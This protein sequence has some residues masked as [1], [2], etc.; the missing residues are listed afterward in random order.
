MYCSNCGQ[1]PLDFDLFA[2]APP[3]APKRPAAFVRPKVCFAS[4]LLFDP[5][6]LF[7]GEAHLFIPFSLIFGDVL[8]PREGALI[9]V[10][11][12][13]RSI[14]KPLFPLMGAIVGEAADQAQKTSSTLSFKSVRKR[15]TKR[16]S[17]FPPW[18]SSMK[19]TFPRRLGAICRDESVF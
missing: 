1:S 7:Q 9:G 19:V 17:G 11:F 16:K 18:A 5:V 15:L 13:L 2:L 14:V 6:A 12:N 8:L 3:K 10:R 4:T